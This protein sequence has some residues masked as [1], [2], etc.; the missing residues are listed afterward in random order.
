MKKKL[1]SVNKALVGFLL[2]LILAVCSAVAISGA[3]TESEPLPPLQI[4]MMIAYDGIEFPQPDNEA[5]RLIEEYTNTKLVITAYPGSTVHELL[6]TMIASNELPMVTSFGGSQLTRPYMVN[7]MR[8]GIFWDLTDVIQQFENLS[9]IPE[10]AYKNY[11]LDGHLYGL[12]KERGIAR[13]AIAY[14]YDWLQNLGMDE[15]ETLDDFYAMLLAFTKDDPDQNGKDDT[16]GSATAQVNRFAALH[17]AP[18]VWEFRDSTM[19]PARLAPEY[20]EALDKMREM[21][22]EGVF[23]K[24]TAIL[25]RS[26][27]EALFT[28]GIAG[29]Y[30]NINSSGD[31]S[32]MAQSEAVIRVNGVFPGKNG[33]FTTA[34]NGHNGINTISTGSVKDEADMLRIVEFFDK[35]GDEVMCNQLVLGLEGVH[36]NIINGEAVSIPEMEDERNSIFRAYS[37]PIAACYPDFRI[38]PIKQEYWERRAAEILEE[39]LPYAKRN[40]A[41]GLISDTYIEHGADLDTMMSD[42]DVQYYM[43]VI[44]K[45]AYI[46]ILQQWRERGGDKI[47]D[48]YT[49]AYKQANGIQ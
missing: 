17:G 26:Q 25:E 1:V 11:A 5:Q 37:G 10:I 43:G 30:M 21:Y 2:V 40:D 33:T 12:P 35:L 48:E 18:N 8:S 6:P 27:F 38:I 14:R 9:S 3:S 4:N 23:H 34:G 13:D 41:T 7:A 20:M 15:P 29:V 22:A 45:D 44:D 42:A 36:Y 47:I 49:A 32:R 28:E 24:E 46:T 19:V 16:Y 39:N 31:P